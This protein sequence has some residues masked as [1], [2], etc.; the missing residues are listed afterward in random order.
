[1]M[2][3]IFSTLKSSGGLG[4]AYL[5][6]ICREGRNQGSVGTYVR[7][8]HEKKKSEAEEMNQ[9]RVAR[10]HGMATLASAQSHTL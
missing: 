10:Y 2:K 1:M 6:S 9:L 3:H 7:S 4:E 8:V 5:P